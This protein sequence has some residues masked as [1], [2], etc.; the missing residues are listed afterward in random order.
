MSQ[1]MFNNPT[2]SLTQELTQSGNSLPQN[3]N[4]ILA[5]QQPNNAIANN[6][7]LYQTNLPNISVSSSDIDLTISEM[8]NN[9]YRHGSDFE[10]HNMPSSTQ[11]KK[12]SQTNSEY[13]MSLKERLSNLISSENFNLAR[14]LFDA[15]P[16]NLHT[17]D[18]R[19]KDTIVRYIENVIYTKKLRERCGVKR[20]PANI[21]PPFNDHEYE[22]LYSEKLY[23]ELI[24]L[25]SHENLSAL[26]SALSVCLLQ[27]PESAIQEIVVANLSSV[28]KKDP[29]PI[30]PFPASN[31]LKLVPKTEVHQQTELI[32]LSSAVNVIAHHGKNGNPSQNNGNSSQHN[33]NN[34]NSCL[35][36]GN[37]QQNYVRRVMGI[38][39]VTEIRRIIVMEIRRIKGIHRTMEIRKIMGRAMEIRK[40]MVRTMAIHRIMATT[41]I[42]KIMA[43]AKMIKMEAT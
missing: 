31:F 6:S 43:A 36:N 14:F 39:R 29:F 2:T 32:P 15:N 12:C 27:E 30:G 18:M 42:L 16:M 28:L 9:L 34:A 19:Y 41:E 40:I 7:L 4:S 38:H 10:H 20:D 26:G 3:L 8:V 33:E 37:L 11:D 23:R 13:I 24:A 5:G 1:P 21:S 17:T 35:N 22:Y 25:F